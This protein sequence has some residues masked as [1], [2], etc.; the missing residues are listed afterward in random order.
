MEGWAPWLFYDWIFDLAEG[1]VSGPIAR[2]LE[3]IQRR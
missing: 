2:P 3:R 1:S